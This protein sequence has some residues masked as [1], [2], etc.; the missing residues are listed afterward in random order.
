MNLWS[1]A[2][3]GVGAM[4]GAGILALL[5]QAALLAGRETYLA[6]IF[7][8]VL[9]VA[10][11]LVILV[12]IMVAGSMD[13][14]CPHEPRDHGL[15]SAVGSFIIVSLGAVRATASGINAGYSAP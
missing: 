15:V 3:L 2:S 11:K 7:A 8:E 10:I 9:L 13:L 4:M 1:M 12:G 5:G 6:F 14:R